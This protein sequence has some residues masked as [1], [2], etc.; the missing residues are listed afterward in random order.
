MQEKS[1]PHTIS[2]V[3]LRAA[4]GLLDWTDADLAEKSGVSFVTISN[5]VTGKHRPTK[6]TKER[7]RKA[8]EDAGVQFLNG[9][10]PGVRMSGATP[11]DDDAA[12]HHDDP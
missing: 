5:W 4:K 12:A 6:S 8:F 11:G 1:K 2:V 9:G 3:H 10:R 7:I